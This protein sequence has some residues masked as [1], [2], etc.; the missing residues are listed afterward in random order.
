MAKN[1]KLSNTFSTGG[2]GGHFEAH[3]QASF[4]ALM[5]TGGYAPCLP[6][7]PI[8]E[9]RLQ[10]KIDG[11]DT[12]DL[13]VFVENE[14]TKD[15]RKLLAQVKHSVTI[16]KGSKILG[17]VIQA[18]WNDFNNPQV[19]N[20]SKDVISLITGPLRETDSRT[21][22]WLLNKARHTKSFEEFIRDVTQ[23]NFSP[24]KSFEKLEVIRHHL[25]EANGG[26]DVLDDDLY[27]FLRSFHLLG[28]DLGNEFGVVLSLLHSHISQFNKQS[29][30]NIWRSVVDI[31]QTWN[32]YGG[33][34]TID[35]IP[36]DIR[37]EFK[38]KSRVEMPDKLKATQEKP[39]ASL[40]NH[41]DAAYLA[42]AIM[43]GSWNDRNKP[44]LE[45]V[46]QILGIS[47]EE[48][49]NKARG[50]LHWE[51]SPL[52]L[53]DGIWKVVDRANLWRT[54]G[55]HILDPNLDVLRSLAISV[56]KEIDP[57]FDLP[58][59]D[60]YAASV[61][62]KGMIFSPALRKGIAE[63]M[64]ILG[65]QP[66]ACVNCSQGKAETTCSQI[67][68]EL[69]S[70]ADWALWGSLNGLLP[71]LAEAAPSE[72]IN[73]VESALRQKPCPFD[74]IFSQEG[75]G[76]TGGNYLTGLLWALEGL[77]WDEQYLV[78][79]CAVLAELSTHDPGGKWLNRP[80]NSL[81]TILLPW[82][83][84]TL[85][86]FDKRKVAVRTILKEWPD[87]GWA[88]IAELLPGRHQTTSGSHKPI[89]R[90]I[91]PDNFEKGVSNDEYWQQSSFYAE[92]AVDAAGKDVGRIS[93]LIDHFDG[94]TGPAFDRLL[95]VLASDE[96]AGLPEEN[97]LFIWDRL[98]K[99][100]KRHRRFS[101]AD[102][103]LPDNLLS[104]IEG[105]AEK[106]APTDPFYLYQHIFADN[107]HELYDVSGDWEKQRAKLEARRDNA[108]I[109]ILQKF[110]FEGVLNFSE[111]VSSPGQVGHALGAVAQQTIEDALLPSFLD[112]QDSKRK[113]LISCFI[114]RRFHL[115]GWEWC[116]K[117]DKSCWTAGQIGQFLAWLPFTKDTWDR[118]SG[119]LHARDG[120]YWN[121]ADANAYQADGDV[122]FAIQKL[123]ENGRPHAAIGCLDMMRHSNKP[124][125]RSQCVRVL[126]AA[127]S[128]SEPSYAINGHRI[129]ELIKFLQAD[130]EADVDDLFKIEWAYLSLLDRHRGA[131]PKILES[132]LSNDPE[133][134]CDVVR[135]IYRSKNEGQN[136][137][138]PT[139]ASKEM[140]IN[141]WR[142]LREWKTPPGMH[143]DGVFSDEG[144][145]VW[146]QRVKESCAQS[147]H[148]DAAL[149]ITGEVLIHAPSDADGLWINRTVAE[150][151]NDREAE[152]MR[153][154]Y[155]IGRYNSRGAH[156]VDPSG[157]P[158]IR[159]AEEFRV[160]AEALE[161]AGF[162]RFSVTV[163]E[164]AETYEC[165]AQR[166]ITDHGE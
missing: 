37:E 143:E 36:E 48:W 87:I 67:L 74:E 5:L 164:L 15:R 33:T 140:A 34:I 157:A 125:D 118:A 90:K 54:L 149:S 24:P 132:R 141:A 126:L 71:D 123:V 70:D 165:E 142:L 16:T 78:R 108:I 128:S 2:G 110:G 11:F 109:E 72:F 62:G 122:N 9:I 81:V 139:E 40:A 137:N 49:L 23:A 103:A 60:R 30:K 57:A 76:L 152:R 28:Y 46:S 61:Y 79:V 31:V 10:G 133:F 113:A 82:L 101:D 6:C 22:P 158:E 160:K 80:S 53:K 120:E 4:V 21:M 26:K 1:K 99:F 29:A 88:L 73:V 153:S 47:Y 58:A 138:E 55:S 162:H 92:L 131:S 85:A 3:I 12:D 84:Q 124:I 116:D 63:G 89:W 166:I 8:V 86:S 59:D 50:I 38:E 64:A 134:F 151:L 97:K 96:V 105:V 32:Q 66:E 150:A 94:L 127:V 44:D 18:A 91:I 111:V 107:D 17:E 136:L 19:F 112:S 69:M 95:Q 117:V 75:N 77:A 135:L 14:T 68:R 119:W 83:P 154:G 147:G 25:K 35:N 163:R 65:S 98:S 45:V 20:K 39:K 106:L 148:L 42:L 156:W 7:W 129:I 115:T 100:A 146:L 52:S 41:P 159:L 43:I 161:N 13:V 130:T 114:W 121:R 155:R 144:F 27:E 104:R 145:T 102:W 93:I 56:L 51:N